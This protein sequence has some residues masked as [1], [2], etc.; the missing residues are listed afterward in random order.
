MR[1]DGV[2]VIL[3]GIYSSTRQAIKGPA[4]VEGK[5]LYIYPEQYEGQESD[6]LDS[7]CSPPGACATGRSVDPV[8]DGEDGAKRFYLPSADYIG[9]TLE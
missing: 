5:T 8:A 6:P 2:D 9:R 1:Q 7:I 4:V 3:G